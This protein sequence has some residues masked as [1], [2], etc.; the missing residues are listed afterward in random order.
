MLYVDPRS[1]LPPGDHNLLG[2]FCVRPPYEK[3][4]WITNRYFWSDMIE[5]NGGVRTNLK[6]AF[7]WQQVELYDMAPSRRSDLY[8]RMPLVEARY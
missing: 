1:A 6:Y 2:F 4:Y 8:L 7:C 3:L 5:H